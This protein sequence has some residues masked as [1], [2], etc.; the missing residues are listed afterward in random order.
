[1][2]EARHERPGSSVCVGTLVGADTRGGLQVIYPG[3]PD[4]GELPARTTVSVSPRDVG[5]Q[6]VLVFEEGDPSRPIVLGLLQ[7]RPVVTAPAE[8]SGVLPARTHPHVRADGE[9]VQI[10]ATRELVLR[11]GKSS[12]TLRSDG[13]V[14]V[15]GMKIVSRAR[16]THK[17]K[18]GDVLIN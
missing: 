4:P 1:M 12:I 8:V 17:I 13:Q 3:Q 18:G 14:F 16:G 11:C 10:E 15:K 9:R 5:R 6:V 2:L 7:A